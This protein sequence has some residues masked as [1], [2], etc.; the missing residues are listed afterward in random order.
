M[1]AVF[2]SNVIAKSVTI[3]SGTKVG[4]LDLGGGFLSAI[5]LP[6]T[7]TSTAL[8]FTVASAP[9]GTYTSLCDTSGSAISYT[10]AASKAMAFPKD[11]FAPWQY[12]TLNFGTNE[13]ADRTIIYLVRGV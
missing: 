4:V 10:V 11:T 5:I 8:T 3:A 1:T 2:I 13:G 12:V 6:G 9:D 7:L